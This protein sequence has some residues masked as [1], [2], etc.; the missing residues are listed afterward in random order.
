MNGDTMYGIYT[1]LDCGE[2]FDVP[3]KW[4]E[5]HGLDTPPYEELNG[6]PFCGG[7]YAHT[8]LCD[9]CKKPIIGDYV[10]IQTTGRCYCDKHFAMRSL[11]D[12]DI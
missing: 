4:V 1:C 10:K 9:S 12:D 8:I 6:C 7:A 3:K 11:E 5:R 2:T